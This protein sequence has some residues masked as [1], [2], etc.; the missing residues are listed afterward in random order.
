MSWR[1]GFAPILSRLSRK[2][3]AWG[4]CETGRKNP[5]I[6]LCFWLIGHANVPIDEVVSPQRFLVGICLAQRIEHH[7]LRREEFDSG[8]ARKA[9]EIFLSGIA[10]DSD[11]QPVV[12]KGDATNISIVEIRRSYITR[13]WIR[14][15]TILATQ[16]APGAPPSPHTCFCG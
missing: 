8:H 14:H 9:D 7:V 5:E 12:A 4:H 15:A 2:T 3:S 10:F 13:G 11:L 1:L 6:G 16:H